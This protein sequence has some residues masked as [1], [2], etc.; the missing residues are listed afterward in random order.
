[1]I[2]RTYYMLVAYEGTSF[3]G[4]QRQ[5]EMRTVQGLVEQAVRRTC[6]HQVDVHGS[7][8]TDA[9]VHA[10]GQVA[11][12]VTTSEIP[13]H[14]LQHA[15]GSRLPKD[16]SIVALRK[17]ADDFHAQ[18]SAVSKCYR[19]RIHNMPGRPVERLRQRYTYHYWKPLDIDRMREGARHMV[20]RQDYTALAAKAGIKE[21]MVRN[22]LRCDIERRGAEI[23][24]SVVGEGFLY[25]QV[26]NM[27]GTLIKVGEHA[28]EPGY[29]ADIIASR[30][31]DNAGPTA[32][33]LGLC[34]QWVRYP[35]ADLRPQVRE[36]PADE[37][38]P[39][40]LHEPI[41]VAD[42]FE[43]VEPEPPGGVPTTK[44]ASLPPGE[45]E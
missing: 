18:H 16:V 31:R 30:D 12:F 36:G 7:G 27:A 34:L 37:E 23:W 25:N 11:S 33:A 41:P 26:R 20:G 45:N 17:V 22:V 9:G 19:Y 38:T 14:K 3:H 2:E 21:D 6:R 10:A 1:M 44:P 29:V 24:I 4:W 32:P 43:P 8:R 28:W 42:D 35:A 5:P 13:P 15:I 39:R 40:G